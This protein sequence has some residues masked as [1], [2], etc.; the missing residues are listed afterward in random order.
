MKEYG[1][2]LPIEL[3]NRKEYFND[4]NTVRLNSGRSAIVYACKEGGFKRVLLPIYL[5]NSV[6]DAL[7]KHNIEYD[8]YNID[9]NFMPIN[10]EFQDG[11]IILYPNYYGIA[12]RENADF[13]V[14]KYKNVI[15]DNTQAFFEKPILNAYNVYSCR[16]F[17]GVSDGAYL[18]KKGI[19]RLRLKK[20]VSYKRAYY[21]LKAIELG[22]DGAY[23]DS[24]SN[25]KII[26]ELP[27]L[28]MSELTRRILASINYEFVIDQRRK[29]F[30]HMHKILG[31]HN[32]LSV[33]LS[34]D[35]VPMV[36]PFLN[37]NKGLRQ[38]LVNNKV[39][40]PQW[41]KSV[42]DS[43]R[44]NEFEKELSEFLIP[45][46]IDQRYNIEDIEYTAKMV[47]SFL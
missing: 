27:L 32:K 45:L 46:P 10:L 43:D 6:A 14:Q 26:A 33:K 11:D 1:G 12:H 9:N 5:C 37:M 42:L 15:I 24:L 7:D 8:Y 22:T 44:A 47:Q 35:T 30:E 4:K 21:L 41:W 29:N 18:I 40:V 16:K 23:K 38:Y 28:S 34:P 13:L 3:I 31:R 39:Y 36:Y 2:Y 17:F 25:E 19:K 20:D